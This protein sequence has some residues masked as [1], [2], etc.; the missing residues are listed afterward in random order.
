MRAVYAAEEAQEIHKQFA[1]EQNF[2][3]MIDKSIDDIESGADGAQFFK[4]WQEEIRK[5]DGDSSLYHHPHHGLS[6]A[7]VGELY[8]GAMGA[9]AIGGASSLRS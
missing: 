1:M 5:N 4:A 3:K 9:A 7:Q 6:S 8:F 2:I